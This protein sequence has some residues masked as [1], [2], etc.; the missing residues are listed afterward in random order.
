MPIIAFESRP[1]PGID[2]IEILPSSIVVFYKPAPKNFFIDRLFL[3]RYGMGR[4]L[5]LELY[6]DNKQDM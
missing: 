3:R 4:G 2:R 5:N 6:F 1:A